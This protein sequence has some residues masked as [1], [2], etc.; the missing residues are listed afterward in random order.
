MDRMIFIVAIQREP[1]PFVIDARARL[2]LKVAVVFSAGAHICRQGL[3]A[4]GNK[5]S[6]Q[7]RAILWWNVR[8]GRLNHQSES[9]DSPDRYRYHPLEYF[10]QSE[11]EET[12]VFSFVPRLRRQ[13]RPPHS[14]FTPS[15]CALFFIFGLSFKTATFSL[16]IFI[17]IIYIIITIIFI[18]WEFKASS[19]G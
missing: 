2:D 17:I 7:K 4:G 18:K 3:G 15:F 5:K 8:C 16:F 12:T 1:L 10:Q 19:S 6:K 13:Q 9:S 14:D 11:K